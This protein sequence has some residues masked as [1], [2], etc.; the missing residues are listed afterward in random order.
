MVINVNYDGTL[1]CDHL[2]DRNDDEHLCSKC[3]DSLEIRLNGLLNIKKLK[4]GETVLCGG[5]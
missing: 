5:K 3:K 1:G 4:L 2:C